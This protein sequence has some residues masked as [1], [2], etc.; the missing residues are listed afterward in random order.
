M[1]HIMNV[2]IHEAGHAVVAAHLHMPFSRVLLAPKHC[3]PE[4]P[5]GEKW[6][7]MVD[8]RMRGSFKAKLVIIRR[9]RSIFS[10]PEAILRKKII[11]HL[12]KHIM[13]SY[14]GRL[15]DEIYP[16]GGTVSNES[17]A[18]A[19]K[20]QEDIRKFQNW[21]WSDDIQAEVSDSR[22]AQLRRRTERIIRIPYVGFAIEETAF[23]LATSKS[24]SLSGKEVRS[25][26]RSERE[27]VTRRG[28]F[29]GRQN[30]REG[31]YTDGSNPT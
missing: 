20:D 10:D 2:A 18:G 24:R 25:V 28:N 22:C 8:M 16:W 21:Q 23:L 31:E 29:V 19:A 13:I 11:E 14:A 6:F 9:G 7:G 1:T 15:A 27:S 12:E 17:S 5:T 4:L 30:L 26:Y 3:V